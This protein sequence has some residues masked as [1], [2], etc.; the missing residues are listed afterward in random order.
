W[1]ITK[2]RQ[3]RCRYQVIDPASGVRRVVPGPVPRPPPGTPPGVISPNG[4]VAA[5]L[6]SGPGHRPQLN[7]I[8]LVTGADRALLVSQSPVVLGDGTPGLAWSPDSRWLFAA[9]ARGSVIAISPAT[10]LARGLGVP[11]P[12]VS[13]LAIRASG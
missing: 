4:L 10:G 8:N 1:M 11:L 9:T 3:V 2:C 6:R 13:Q 7:L 12:P 5:V